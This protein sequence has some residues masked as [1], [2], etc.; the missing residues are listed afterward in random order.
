MFKRASTLLKLLRK[1]NSKFIQLL[2]RS[3]LPMA[4]FATSCSP[5]GGVSSK[6]HLPTKSTE[7]GT[8]GK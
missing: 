1:P 6:G 5:C 2:P 8:D 3:I 7:K 4:T